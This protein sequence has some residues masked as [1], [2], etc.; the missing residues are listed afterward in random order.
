MSELN[1]KHKQRLS[2]AVTERLTYIVQRECCRVDVF[3]QQ[4]IN[5]TLAVLRISVNRS[6]K[7]VVRDFLSV[8]H[9]EEMRWIV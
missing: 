8:S 4:T 7:N 6:R 2:Q 5:T 3:V 9:G 1:R